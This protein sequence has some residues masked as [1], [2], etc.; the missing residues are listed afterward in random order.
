MNQFIKDHDSY[1]SIIIKKSDYVG[2][3]TY[4]Y[5]FP[6]GSID[7]KR[8][9]IAFNSLSMNLSYYNIRTAFNNRI[10]TIGFPEGGSYVYNQITI[11]EGYYTIEQLNSY[12][13]FWCISQNYY[14]INDV[15]NYVYY[16]EIVWN[17]VYGRVQLNLYNVPTVAEFALLTGWTNPG[18]SLPTVS[19]RR[20]I[21]VV[22]D[23]FGKIIGFEPDGLGYN[24]ESQLGQFAPIDPVDTIIVQCTNLDNKYSNPTN[25]LYAF[26]T[27]NYLESSNNRYINIQNV[28]C[29]YIDLTDGN[30]PYIEIK[31]VDQDNRYLEIQDPYININLIIKVRENK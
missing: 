17:N 28:E 3:G 11:P 7:V 8:S 14:L 16:V 27:R 30:I 25:N 5:S 9:S 1:Y 26:S 15:G 4:R 31:L 24:D 10:F 19:G 22:G 20:P 13:Q 6:A 2:N 18:W 23:S 29:N 12:I 21:F